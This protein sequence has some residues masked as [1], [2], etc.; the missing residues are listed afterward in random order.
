MRNQVSSLSCVINAFVKWEKLTKVSF[1]FICNFVSSRKLLNSLRNEFR[2]QNLVSFRTISRYN[3]LFRKIFSIRRLITQ[4]AF[5]FR[6]SYLTKTLV[7][8]LLC[9][10]DKSQI[11]RSSNEIFCKLLLILCIQL[12]NLKTSQTKEIL[13]NLSTRVLISTHRYKNRKN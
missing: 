4:L 13:L 7:I 1:R 6:I 10:I 8:F 9:W 2:H 12:Q 11:S 5:L 3:R